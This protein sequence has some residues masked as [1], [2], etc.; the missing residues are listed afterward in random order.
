VISACRHAN[1]HWRGRRHQ[2][3]PTFPRSPGII[4]V[5]HPAGFSGRRA[6]LKLFHGER[7]ISTF[8]D[9]FNPPHRSSPSFSEAR[10][11]EKPVESTTGIIPGDRGKEG[12]SW[13]RPPLPMGNHRVG[14]ITS[15]SGQC[16]DCS[17][18][19]NQ[20]LS[21]QARIRN[22]VQ[23][24]SGS[25]EVSTRRPDAV[26]QRVTAATAQTRTQTRIPAGKPKVPPPKGPGR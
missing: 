24:E 11:Y 1:A 8:D 12:G 26:T 16:H 15:S 19:M 21:G 9:T 25:R 3:L 4:P 13:C 2:L 5:V 18:D 20:E 6:A 22:R 14:K 23:A 17:S 7:A 10:R